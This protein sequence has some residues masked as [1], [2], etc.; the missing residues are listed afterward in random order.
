[1]FDFKNKLGLFFNHI[2]QNQKTMKKFLAILAIV[3]VM[4]SCKDN[5][6]EEPTTTDPTTTTTD[7]P[8]TTDEPTTT[9][10][11]AG[12]TTTSE[13]VPKFSDPDVQKMANDYAAF[14]S[15]YKAGMN[16]PQKLVGLTKRMQDWSSK[17]SEISTK[18]ASK[19]EEAMAWSDWLAKMS[20]SIMPK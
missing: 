1:M 2:N 3:G 18:L 15:E 8:T 19:P 4:V 5:K 20:K 6:K 9:T 10:T 17:L 16:D 11:D 13:D 7:A 12:S 14:M